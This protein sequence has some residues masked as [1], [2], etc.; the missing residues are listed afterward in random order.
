MEYVRFCVQLVPDYSNL[1]EIIKVLCSFTEGR[2]FLNSMAFRNEYTEVLYNFCQANQFKQ[3]FALY[4]GMK[5]GKMA[6]YSS[7]AHVLIGCFLRQQQY[8]LCMDVINKLTQ[9]KVKW[10]ARPYVF[11]MQH[12][13]S[14][15]KFNYAQQLY[16]M[17]L[18]S[19]LPVDT[20][21]WTS[22]IRMFIA[23]GDVERAVYMAEQIDVRGFSPSKVDYTMLISD[24]TNAKRYQIAYNMYEKMTRD[25]KIVMDVKLGTSI[26]KM[27]FA[28]KKQD[29][30]LTMM[31]QM[32]KNGV[33]INQVTYTTV[34]SGCVNAGKYQ[35]ALTLYKEVVDNEMTFSV[36][37]YNTILNMYCEMS[38]IQT[39][40]QILTKMK[41]NGVAAT[42]PT[43]NI[44][45]NGCLN[46]GLSQRALEFYHQLSKE[47]IKITV[48][49]GTTLCRLFCVVGDINQAR[50]ILRLMA[51]RGIRDYGS[52]YTVM[53]N[54]C[55]NTGMYDEALQLYKDV[56]EKNIT[57]T[58]RLGT[59]IMKM[60][61]CRGEPE[62]ARNML[63]T[64]KDL[65]IGLEAPTYVVMINGYID[66][67]M[68]EHALQLYKEFASTDI[69]PSTELYNSLIKLYCSM[70]VMDK[71]VEILEKMKSENIELSERT[72]TLMIS[73]FLQA[74]QSDQGI[75]MFNEARCMKV[76][77][78]THL[79][80]TAMRAM[81]ILNQKQ[82]ALELLYN[83]DHLYQCK[84]EEM[85]YS[86]LLE[87]ATEKA[88]TQYFFTVLNHSR[89]S[90]MKRT[91][92]FYNTLIRKYFDLGM[93]DEAFKTYEEMKVSG[94]DAVLDTFILLISSPES[95]LFRTQ[96]ENELLQ[97]TC[98]TNVE[99][100]AYTL[101]LGE[102]ANF[103]QMID[104]FQ[105]LASVDAQLWNSLFYVC[106]VN[107]QGKFA[108]KM[109]YHML[110]NKK[111]RPNLQTFRL[112]ISACSYKENVSAAE[113]VYELGKKTV[114]TGELL[115]IAMIDVYARG[116]YL[117]KA[118]NMAQIIR[119]EKI[120]AWIIVLSGCKT[121]GDT[122]RAKRIMNEHTYLQEHG[123][124]LLLAQNITAEANDRD[125]RPRYCNKML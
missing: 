55:T 15:R 85:T 29:Q 109:L 98:M 69:A 79:I 48:S 118:E 125:L 122:D 36:E 75:G 89:L 88:D 7:L 22:F 72:Y 43:Y 96:L 67:G 87:G 56:K 94:I 32:K 95:L 12:L 47:E 80:T 14:A 31:R 108:I 83:M 13:T 86:V 70:G 66:V 23:E 60:Y 116:G 49:L 30:A 9:D 76:P 37:L 52:L 44:M 77:I 124:V 38:D 11:L 110:D 78:T 99:R 92:F 114:K 90:S 121:Y 2:Y 59:S 41:Q 84:P 119:K 8:D 115:D 35:E 117:Q 4:Q 104:S 17:I 64:M 103:N 102:K 53:I 63:Q 120:M 10:N 21:L 1:I 58:L 19:K 5:E 68:Y 105:D 113:K 26:L 101:C 16:E 106:S 123:N 18:R 97:K 111:A 112:V 39:A 91:A 24:F 82:T 46:A 45:I 42:G 28:L 73:G 25:S 62:S 74:G 54:D 6:L 57:I 33:K 40:L 27:L 100:C 71:A 107:G 3:A 65:K 51:S 20:Q 34:I 61:C 50:N 81:I 93:P